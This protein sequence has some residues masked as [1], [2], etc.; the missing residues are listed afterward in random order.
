MLSIKE[1]LKNEADAIDI[2][3]SDKQLEC[4]ELYANLLE[5]KNRHINLT[6]VEGEDE[7]IRRHFLDSIALSKMVDLSGASLIDVGTGA[8][9]PGLPLKILDDSIQLT[10]LDS[11]GKR[12]EFLKEL[13]ELLQIRVNCVQGRAEELSHSGVYRDNYDFAVSRALARLNTLCEFCVPYVKQSGSFLAM[14]SADS[15]EE[16][17]EAKTA[18]EVLNAKVDRVEKYDIGGLLRSVIIIKKIDKTPEGYPRR[19]ARIQKKPL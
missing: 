18:L 2:S 3:L 17:E 8:G 1:K 16:Q 4:F 11:L 14:K 10:L 12:I 19:F 15:E 7:I 9:F 5:E 6:S 13:C